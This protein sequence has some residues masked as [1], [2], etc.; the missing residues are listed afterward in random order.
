MGL[1]HK[2]VEQKAVFSRLNPETQQT[3]L[4]VFLRDIIKIVEEMRKEIFPLPKGDLPFN[5]KTGQ[6]DI[7]IL[8]LK[9]WLPFINNLRKWLMPEPQK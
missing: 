2:R 5:P 8:D 4:I 1:L 9:D 7:I 3:E 6:R